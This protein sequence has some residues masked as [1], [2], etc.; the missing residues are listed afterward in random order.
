MLHTV[1]WDVVNLG[2]SCDIISGHAVCS[3]QHTRLP[4]LPLHR[5]RG[6]QLQA[7]CQ[8]PC[9]ASISCMRLQHTFGL[10]VLSAPLYRL[11]ACD[12]H[13]CIVI[14]GKHTQSDVPLQAHS[15]RMGLCPLG[16]GS[17]QQKLRLLHCNRLSSS[18]IT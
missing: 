13:M 5:S 4:Q 9:W 2:M 12:C 10:V 17:R 11:D 8:V 3:H 6:L 1:A 18:R 7:M 15:T 16:R 14:W